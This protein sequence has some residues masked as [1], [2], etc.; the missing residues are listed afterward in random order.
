MDTIL[1]DIFD[2]RDLLYRPLLAALPVKCDPPDDLPV[3]E[4]QKGK[5]C[6]GHT[7]AMM[8]EIGLRTAGKTSPAYGRLPNGP[9]TPR[10]SAE[11]LYQLARRYDNELG[12]VGTSLRA[13][14]KGWY[15]HGVALVEQWKEVTDI[16]DDVFRQ[17]CQERPLGAYFRVNPFRL[18]DVQS[19]IWETHAVA[20]AL[21]VPTT[22]VKDD[23]SSTPSDSDWNASR[24][25]LHLHAL[26]LVGY[27]ETGFIALNS[28]GPDWGNEG[29]SSIPYAAWL[30]NAVD[31]WVAR[32]GV[33][34]TPLPDNRTRSGRS[35]LDGPAVQRAPNR[36]RLN[37]HVINL[38]LDGGFR[39]RGH[40]VT[41]K[42]RAQ[43]IISAAFQSDQKHV[44]LWFHDSLIP[45]EEQRW[46]ADAKVEWWLNRGIYPIYVA[47]S[48]R[49]FSTRLD[50]LA[51]T[52]RQELPPMGVLFDMRNQV[53]RRCEVMARAL[54]SSWRELVDDL[55]GGSQAKNHVFP[56]ISARMSCLLATNEEKNP[57][58]QKKLHLIA[59][60][61]GC[62]YLLS[63]LRFFQ[64][65]ESLLRSL[66]FLTPTCCHRDF[67]N[68]L[69]TL[70]DRTTV[71]RFSDAFERTVG[72]SRMGIK[73]HTQSFLTIVARSLAGEIAVGSEWFNGGYDLPVRSEEAVTGLARSAPN[74][75]VKSTHEAPGPFSRA[76]TL[77]EFSTDDLTLESIANEM[78]SAE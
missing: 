68:L 73:L 19:A 4:K 55:P 39:D 67:T 9:Q 41:S 2:H 27:D 71:F 13:A 65:S 31:T 45:D 3:P 44:M 42:G 15:H 37:T 29:T 64:G 35:T 30:E 21:F 40:H 34:S 70:C 28:Y 24:E 12:D 46:I 7:V 50:D 17:H 26:I 22:W 32:V 62:S 8:I 10:V 57:K 61:T 6:V 49:F 52:I 43:Q 58:A 76:R 75:A 59:A 11:M 16:E 51:R 5:H 48:S 25:D 72:C 78:I 36:K 18:D 60:G 20:A 66:T 14:L 47:W 56:T 38:G 54:A 74:L 69:G 1:A 77:E 53:D 63:L 23:K 33:P